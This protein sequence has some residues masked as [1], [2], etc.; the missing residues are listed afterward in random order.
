MDNFNLGNLGNLL[1]GMQQRV[2]DMKAKQAALRCEGVAGDGLVKITV[3][4]DF[5]VADVHIS[6]DALDD[7]EL[8]EDLVRAALSEALRQVQ[9]EMAKGMQEIT[10]GL[11]IPPGLLPM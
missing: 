8:L 1:G 7:R 10:G 3:T 4:G 9:A 6:P 2:A 11:P 5:Q